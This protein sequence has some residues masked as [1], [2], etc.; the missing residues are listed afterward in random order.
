MAR[1]IRIGDRVQAF[2]DASIVGRVVD[3]STGPSKGWT[4]DGT[5][6][7]STTSCTVLL[8]SSDKKVVV[9]ASDLFIVDY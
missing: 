5:L 7:A 8:E 1:N 3:I 9:K 2:L 6:S 4:V